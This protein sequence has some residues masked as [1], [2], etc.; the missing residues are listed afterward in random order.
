MSIMSKFPTRYLKPADIESGKIATVDRV[1]DEI[2]GEAQESKPVI[3]FTDYVKGA[4]LNKTN[5]M[6][7]AA[8]F[9]DDESTWDGKKVELTTIKVRK[10]RGGGLVDSIAMAPAPTKL[11]RA[12]SASD[13]LDDSIPF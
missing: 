4:V 5:A 10:P 3:Y 7:L 11:T 12:K 8:V 6:V 1:E 9:G 2:M 13:D